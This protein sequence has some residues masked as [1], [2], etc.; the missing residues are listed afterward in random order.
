MLAVPDTDSA[1]ALLAD[2]EAEQAKLRRLLVAVEETPA[3]TR[4]RA[5]TWSVVE[6]LRHLLAAEQLHLGQF[7]PGPRD[8]SAIGLP[9][10]GLRKRPEFRGLDDTAKPSVAEVM[11]EWEAAHSA[12]RSHLTGDGDKLRHA[13]WKN[14]RHLR[15]HIEVI[16]RILRR[17]ARAAG[18]RPAL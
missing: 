11:Q 1:E 8:Y 2:I 13:L 10:A 7:V 3:S 6:N 14:R 9:P 16:E 12:I 15:N 17:Q 18:T 4:P 5:D